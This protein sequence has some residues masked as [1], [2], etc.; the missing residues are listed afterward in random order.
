MLGG[1]PGAIVRGINTV[2]NTYN[3]VMENPLSFI[4]G[5]RN[6]SDYVG[7]KFNN[8]I[9]PAK[10]FVSEKYNHFKSKAHNFY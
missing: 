6:I 5:A 9:G 10:N 8:F 2:K 7:N 1:I 3:A 4:P